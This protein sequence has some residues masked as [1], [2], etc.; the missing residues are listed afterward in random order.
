M[1]RSL[2]DLAKES[3][4]EKRRELM[5]HIA[6]LFFEGADRYSNDELSLFNDILTNL[7][8]LVEI[9]DRREFSGKVAHVAETPRPLILKLANDKADV[10]APVL[11]HS[12]V[13]TDDDLFTLA[14]TKGQE[15]LLAI[16]QRES[17]KPRITDVLLERGEKP[18]QHSVAA[19]TGAKLSDWGGRL[20]VKLA[21]S[22]RE[23]REALTERHDLSK[24]NFDRLLSMLPADRQAKLRYIFENNER[25][26]RNLFKEAS[27]LVD[28][29]K[30]ERRKSRL[31]SK[32]TL[33]DLRD[34][35]K[36]LDQAVIEYSLS[37]ELY[38]LA[39]LLG[40][41]AQIDERFVRNIMVRPDVEAI[42]VLCKSVGVSDTAFGALCKARC[43]HMRCPSTQVDHWAGEY[44]ILSEAEAQRTMRFIKVRLSVMAAAAA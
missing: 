25:M 39:F 32:A 34:G 17:L 36:Q 2:V 6:S 41:S 21:E 31:N 29:G 5:G 14:R 12:E 43:R 10:A 37:N 13:L 16:A 42:A 35:H 9:E 24:P 22:D 7:L 27:A 30:L 3:C 44:R 18:V 19:N 8:D 4:S 38:E 11:Q 40:Q 28:E 15:H 1:L 23:L 26:A 20:L 33:K